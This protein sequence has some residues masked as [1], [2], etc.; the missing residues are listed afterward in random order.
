MFLIF[1]FWLFE[2]R[3]KSC[4][5]LGIFIYLLK[6]RG[7]RAF[8]SVECRCRQIF[9]DEE[10]SI[11]KDNCS[12]AAIKPSS[13]S[14]SSSSSASRHRKG[15]RNRAGGFAYWEK[16]N[17]WNRKKLVFFLDLYPNL[18][19]SSFCNDFDVLCR[20]ASWYEAVSVL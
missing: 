8:C 12:L 10:E 15:N 18:T 4:V 2:E 3:C 19:R 20:F 11:R 5:F 1:F 6:C 7:D 16:K 14:S 9:M 13:S 17:Q